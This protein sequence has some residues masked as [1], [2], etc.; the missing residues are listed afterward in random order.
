MLKTLTTLK[1]LAISVALLGYGTG[2]LAADSTSDYIKSSAPKGIT[3]T[4]Y[5]CVDK[6]GSDTI[7]IAACLTTER[8]TQDARLNA[9]YKTLLGKLKGKAKDDLISAERAW[10]ELQSKTGPLETAV[11]GSER[12]ANLQIAQNEIF[13]LCE[14]ANALAKY[15]AALDLQ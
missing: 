12:I 4:F 15:L 8:A 1:A 10:I 9:Q 13:R 2:V 14:R 11:Y 3:N 6:A 7:A 5:T